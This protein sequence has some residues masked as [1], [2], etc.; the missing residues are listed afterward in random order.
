VRAEENIKVIIL[1]RPL[2]FIYKL[3]I[4]VLS[5][6]FDDRRG[7]FGSIPNS[8]KAAARPG[9]DT[10]R[11]ATFGVPC[12]NFALTKDG[13][14]MWYLSIAFEFVKC[15]ALKLSQPV[16]LLAPVTS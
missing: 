2:L 3:K 14:F 8:V 10:F 1:L 11:I 12:I 15:F 5:K 6:V 4:E 13:A 16:R 9:F 7:E